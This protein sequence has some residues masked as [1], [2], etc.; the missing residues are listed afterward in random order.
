MSKKKITPEALRDSGLVLKNNGS[1][2]LKRVG[3]LLYDNSALLA[4]LLNRYGDLLK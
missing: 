1:E 4:R 3:E 2:R